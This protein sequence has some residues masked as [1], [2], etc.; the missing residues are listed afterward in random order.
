MKGRVHYI[1]HTTVKFGE[2]ISLR[3]FNAFQK[4]NLMFVC[5][6]RID[7]R[8]LRQNVCTKENIM[9]VRNDIKMTAKMKPE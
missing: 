1:K 4:S 3:Y 7:Q 9:N 5:N 8:A 6:E 2:I